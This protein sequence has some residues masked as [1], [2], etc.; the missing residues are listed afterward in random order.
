MAGT[1]LVNVLVVA[2]EALVG[3]CLIGLPLLVRQMAVGALDVP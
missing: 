1:A 2:A 3:G